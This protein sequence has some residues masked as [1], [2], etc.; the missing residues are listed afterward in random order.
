FWG[1]LSARGL[2]SR[3]VAGIRVAALG[4]A[5]TRALAGR[6]IIP[7][8]ST[9][10]FQPA[11][12]EARL[13]E[14]EPVEGLRMLFPNEAPGGSPV[15]V[16][17][18]AAGILVDEVAT[19]RI[20]LAG[21]ADKGLAPLDVDAIVLPSSTA[22]RAVADAAAQHGGQ[23]ITAR[24]VAIGPRTAETTLGYGLPVHAVAGNPSVGSVVSAVS[25]ILA[26][27]G[28]S[29]AAA[30]AAHVDSLADC[31]PVSLVK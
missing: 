10:T 28:E 1:L 18:R 31:V 26:G 3:A 20:G 24:V 30:G 25:R 14:I 5:T 12:I 7:E 8:L 17:L 27:A 21:R 15:A 6:G 4:A 13:R 22:A 23:A 19:F 29:R 11:S 9:R 2:D 16:G